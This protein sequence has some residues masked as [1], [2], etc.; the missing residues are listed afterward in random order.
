MEERVDFLARQP[1]AGARLVERTTSRRRDVPLPA[2]TNFVGAEARVVDSDS[3][4]H[5]MHRIRRE[6]MPRRSQA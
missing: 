3:F 2:Q 6:E 4:E 1:R 5:R